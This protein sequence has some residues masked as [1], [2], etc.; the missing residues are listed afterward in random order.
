[1][2]HAS[3]KFIKTVDHLNAGAARIARVAVLLM[4]SIGFWNVVGRHLGSALNLNL[5][6]N[7]LIEA[8]L[9]DRSQ[10]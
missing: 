1:M 9:P 6:S 8:W 2:K 3:L 7:D 5:S 10:P 4:L